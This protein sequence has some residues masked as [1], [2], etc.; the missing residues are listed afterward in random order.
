[1]AFS[2]RSTTDICERLCATP[3]CDLQPGQNTIAFGGA[4]SGLRP[5]TAIRLVPIKLDDLENDHI[6]SGSCCFIEDQESREVI[7][8]SLRTTPE[9]TKPATQK[10]TWRTFVAKNQGLISGGFCE[11]IS[12]K[13]TDTAIELPEEKIQVIT[14]LRYEYALNYIQR[15]GASVSRI[16]LGY[17]AY[18]S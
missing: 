7:C 18:P 6:N 4:S 1:V 11:I 10:V 3:A 12:P 14:K 17:A 16:G 15:V 9:E 2:I 13:L 5:F 8:L